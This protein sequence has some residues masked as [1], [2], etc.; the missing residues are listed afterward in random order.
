MLIV[1]IDKGNYWNIQ[2]YDKG[3]L[4]HDTY[5]DA[6]SKDKVIAELKDRFNI[7]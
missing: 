7:S 6:Q 1:P 2:V 5:A 4:I 3:K